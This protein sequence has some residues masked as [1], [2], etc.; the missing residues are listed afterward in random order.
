MEPTTKSPSHAVRWPAVFFAVMVFMSLGPAS[1]ATDSQKILTPSDPSS[2]LAA[3]IRLDDCR[4]VATFLDPA[5]GLPARSVRALARTP[6]GFLWVGTTGGLCRFDGTEFRRYPAREFPGLAADRIL[7]LFVASDGALWVG[8]DRGASVLRDG[9]FHQVVRPEDSEQVVGF[10]ENGSGVWGAG[11]GL[12]RLAGDAFERSPLGAADGPDR[13]PAVNS[14][15][16]IEGGALVSTVAGLFQVQGGT[17]TE[18][19]PQPM[20]GCFRDAGGG[21]WVAFAR[22]GRIAPLDD[23]DDQRPAPRLG[24]LHASVQVSDDSVYVAAAGGLHRAVG[25]GPGFRLERVTRRIRPRAFLLREDGGLWVGTRRRGLASLAVA[26]FERVPLPRRQAEQPAV[27]LVV[28]YGDGGAL[29]ASVEGREVWTYG[30]E[31]ATPVA[32]TRSLLS[33]VMLWGAPLPGGAVLGLDTAGLLRFDA[34]GTT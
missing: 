13:S 26:E 20:F 21:L 34:Q 7:A 18:R 1:V 6:D 28:P 27:G 29:V 5:D 30:A 12:F 24:K 19:S 16:P 11:D 14:L 8:T 17:V 33:G 4:S 9:R 32:D 10:F 25:T 31:G 23:L 15:L 22:I 2:E 3:A